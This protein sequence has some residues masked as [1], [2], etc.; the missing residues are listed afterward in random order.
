M[1]ELPVALLFPQVF[2]KLLVDIIDFKMSPQDAVDK[3]KFHQ[4]WLPDVIYVEHG[5]NENV[6]DSIKKNGL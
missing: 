1:Q 5:F 6:I 3:P 4:Q 2:T